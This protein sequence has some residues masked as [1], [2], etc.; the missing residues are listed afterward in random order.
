MCIFTCFENF[1][2]DLIHYF[3]LEGKMTL[4]IFFLC[5]FKLPLSAGIKCVPSELTRWHG[6]RSLQKTQ[7][8]MGAKFFSLFWPFI[9][10]IFTFT[11][12]LTGCLFHVLFHLQL[13]CLFNF[14]T[15][16]V[17]IVRKIISGLPG[18]WNECGVSVILMRIA[19]EKRIFQERNE[20]IGIRRERFWLKM[21]FW[22]RVRG[23]W[24]L[25]EWNFPFSHHF[26]L[27]FVR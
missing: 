27:Y 17:K 15:K 4:C 23:I 12:W 16:L 6:A 14:S 18:N 10:K 13:F 19:A 11:C 8:V 22:G 26:C 24:T 20:E 2:W 7:C 9:K 25:I 1:Y 5:R 3:T 21:I